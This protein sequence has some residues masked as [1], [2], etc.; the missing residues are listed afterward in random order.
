MHRE[1]PPAD[2]GTA[3]V[4]VWPLSALYSRRAE[5]VRRAWQVAMRERVHVHLVDLRLPRE[6]DPFRIKP[7]RYYA[8]DGIHPS[9]EGYALWFAQITR[10]VPRT[11]FDRSRS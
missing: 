6:R 8:R 11:A 4:W 9:A 10:Q 1:I 3:P 2:I 7:R 5:E